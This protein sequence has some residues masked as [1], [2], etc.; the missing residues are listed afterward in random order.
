MF[1]HPHVKTG[2][3]GMEPADTALTRK[4]DPK[5]LTEDTGSQF[6]TFKSRVCYKIC[7]NSKTQKTGKVKKKPASILCALL[8][9]CY[10]PIEINLLTTCK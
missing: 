9:L 2:W 1:R 7:K 4:P 5:K 3:Y 6:Q 10:F 8:P